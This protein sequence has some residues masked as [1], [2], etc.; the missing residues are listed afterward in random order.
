MSALMRMSVC[1]FG[2]GICRGM[3]ATMAS[4]MQQAP[5]VE[6]DDQEVSVRH[7]FASL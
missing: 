7:S 4:V 2:E 1:G 5:Q 3:V 6:S